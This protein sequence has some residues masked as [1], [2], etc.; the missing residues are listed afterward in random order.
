MG[1]GAYPDVQ[2]RL[3]QGHLE[4]P[5]AAGLGLPGSA[6]RDDQ[7]RG[8]IGVA[9]ARGALSAVRDLVDAPAPVAL[10]VRLAVTRMIRRQLLRA[11]PAVFLVRLGF[12]PPARR[13][14]V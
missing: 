11:R 4:H 1:G 10:P 6:R 7:P 8:V 13:R 5:V 9:G 14:E 3:G 2:A 12:L